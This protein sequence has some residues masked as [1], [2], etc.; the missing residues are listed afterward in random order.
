MAAAGVPR[1]YVPSQL[2]QEQKDWNA[3]VEVKKAVKGEAK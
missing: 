2:T 1:K 3:Q